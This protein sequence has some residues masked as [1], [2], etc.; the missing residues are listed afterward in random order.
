MRSFTKTSLVLLL[1]I[2]SSASIVPITSAQGGWLTGWDYR[3]GITITGAVGA[4]T[5]Y[6]IM[7]TVTYLSEMETDFADVRFTDNDGSTLLDYWIEDYTV[8]TSA[9]VWV[10]VADSL[11]SSAVIYMYYGNDA[12]PT[13]SNGTNTFIFFDDYSTDK[14]TKTGTTITVSGEQMHWDSAASYGDGEITIPVLTN[15]SMNVHF[16]WDTAPNVIAAIFFVRD[17]FG[18]GYGDYNDGIGYCLYW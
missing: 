8:S 6:Q 10:E 15:F 14:L 13:T 4:G 2:L 3:K 12:V 17:D 5:D 9:L 7:L 11:E 16:N 1:F 18:A